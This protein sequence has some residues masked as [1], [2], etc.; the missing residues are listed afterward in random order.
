T[1]RGP[2]A[3]PGWA[4]A[5]SPGPLSAA[6]AF[7]GDRCE[8]CHQPFQGAGPGTCQ[9]C[10]AADGPDLATKPSTTFHAEVSTCA[11]CHVEHLGRDRRPVG[12]DHR[13]LFG[14][15]RGTPRDLRA[16]LERAVALLGDGLSDLGGGPPG[17]RALRPADADRMDCAACHGGQDPHRGLF[18]NA[19]QACHTTAAWGVAG[20]LHPSPASRDCVQCH[21]APPSHYMMHFEMVSRPLAR[22]EHAR[23][24]QCFLCHQT[25]AWNNIRGVGWR[26]HH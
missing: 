17:G 20:F 19:C 5:A 7:L 18:G 10:H 9:A 1:L 4:A 22:Q 13:V 14:A 2:A 16:R 26:K 11:G 25:D 15:A 21:V 8:A 12:M 3:V 6:H 24:E 23:V